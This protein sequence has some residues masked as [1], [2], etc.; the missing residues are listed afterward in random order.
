MRLLRPRNKF[1]NVRVNGKDSKKEARRA[2]ELLL[3]QKANRVRFLNFGVVFTLI[4]AQ[5]I[6]GKCVERAVTYKCDAQYEELQE[7][8]GRPI[9]VKV[10]EDTKSPATKTQQYVIRR[11]LLLHV[12]GIRIRET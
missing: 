12:H 3:L 10:V 2:N 1:G 9:W 5:Y 11:K 8:D 6:D 7:K 4:P